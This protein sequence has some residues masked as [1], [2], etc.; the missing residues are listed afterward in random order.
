M[1]KGGGLSNS[2]L[3]RQVR[4]T[5]Y[6]VSPRGWFSISEFAAYAKPAMEKNGWTKVPDHLTVSSDAGKY[7]CRE[8]ALVDVPD[9]GSWKKD[10]KPGTIVAA[11]SEGGQAHV[12]VENYDGAVK[13]F[14]LSNLLLVPK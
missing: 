1:A 11:W 12:T 5:I 4:P 2:L 8:D 6:M 7:H 3:G 10:F 13:D 14:Y 9:G